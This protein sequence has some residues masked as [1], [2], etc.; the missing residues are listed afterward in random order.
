MDDRR[1]VF[2]REEFRYDEDAR[3]WMKRE[4]VDD[5]Y[6]RFSMECMC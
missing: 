5:A 2:R 6:M 4:V 1:L 3:K